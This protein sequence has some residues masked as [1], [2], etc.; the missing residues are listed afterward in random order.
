[1][2]QPKPSRKKPPV[3]QASNNP[4]AISAEDRN[5]Y[6]EIDLPS[7]AHCVIKRFKGKHIQQAKR[8]MKE[9]G[10]DL[11]ECMASI[12]CTIDGK[13]LLKEEYGELDGLDYLKI[14]EPMNRFFM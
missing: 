8:L 3:T 5:I 4:N 1:M 9:D 11:D 13:T 14:M 7:G 6:M 10:S 12:L 2:Q